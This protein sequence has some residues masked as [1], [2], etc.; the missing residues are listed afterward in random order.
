MLELSVEGSSEY[1]LRV[2]SFDFKMR[3]TTKMIISIVDQN[4][5]ILTIHVD[6]NY[7]TKRIG[8]LFI[9]SFRNSKSILSSCFYSF[10]QNV[11]YRSSLL[12]FN[13]SLGSFYNNAWIYKNY[14]INP[15][16]FPRRL[17]SEEERNLLTM[18]YVS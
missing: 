6:T 4:G 13:G 16:D 17:I 12:R 2:L 1:D 9:T 8:L 11:L 7:H 3:P 15:F 10:L 18:F 14:L 5:A